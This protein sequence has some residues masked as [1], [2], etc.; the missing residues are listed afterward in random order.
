M[1]EAGTEGKVRNEDWEGTIHEVEGEGEGKACGG[2]EEAGAEVGGK[3]R[4]GEGDQEG[5]ICGVGEEVGAEDG[6]AKLQ[7]LGHRHHPPAGVSSG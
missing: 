5:R 6:L 3:V 2:E 1:R 7:E 4:D